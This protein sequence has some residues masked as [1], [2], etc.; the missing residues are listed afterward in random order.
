MLCRKKQKKPKFI[1]SD[2]NFLQ[3]TEEARKSLFDATITGF[4][5]RL[6]EIHQNTPLSEGY[7]VE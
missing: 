7:I 2:I 5:L 1:D 4:V 3:E 6:F